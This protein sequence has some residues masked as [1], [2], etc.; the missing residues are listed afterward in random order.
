MGLRKQKRNGSR[1]NKPA[2]YGARPRTQGRMASQLEEIYKKRTKGNG[3]QI[4][5]S[6]NKKRKRAKAKNQQK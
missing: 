1:L 5:T 4:T 3:F 2:G 6:S